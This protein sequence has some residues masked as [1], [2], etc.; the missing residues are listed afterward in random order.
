MELKTVIFDIDGTLANIDHRLHLI[1]G[2]TKNWKEFFLACVDD[3]PIES[4][5]DTMAAHH[6][7]GHN[8]ILL[9]GR[10]MIVECQT[11]HWVSFAIRRF[12]KDETAIYVPDLYLR[13]KDDFRPDHEIKR[14]WLHQQP[15]SVRESILAVYEDRTQVVN[16]W[17][18]EGVNCYQVAQGDF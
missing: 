16:M 7:A 10:S 13:D 5:F 17:R 15:H 6:N 12:A 4:M 9:T 14:D 3:T 8:V 11:R 1:Q 2:E 18:E